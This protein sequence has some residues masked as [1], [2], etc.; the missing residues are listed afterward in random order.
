MRSSLRNGMLEKIEQA[1]NL[2]YTF[3]V[4]VPNETSCTSCF[5][6]VWAMP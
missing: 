3:F 4:K 1:A 6:S 2:C 5:H